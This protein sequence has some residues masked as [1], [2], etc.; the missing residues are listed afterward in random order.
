M[1]DAT[2]ERRLRDRSRS[3]RGGRRDWD[4]VGFTPLIFLIDDDPSRRELCSI[5]LLQ[6]R[7][8][9]APVASA[10]RALSVIQSLAPDAIV[11]SPSELDAMTATPQAHRSGKNIPVVPLNTRSEVLADALR[12]AFRSTVQSA[13]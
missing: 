6:V 5:I 4:H 1:S 9:V 7:F 3:P 8:A 11:V 10:N 2:H 12:V 13:S